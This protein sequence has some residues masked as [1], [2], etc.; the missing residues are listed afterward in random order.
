VTLIPA[1]VVEMLNPGSEL[2]DLELGPPFY[3]MHGVTD[4]IVFDPETTLVLHRRISETVRR[5]SP[6]TIDLACG[7]RL[8]AYSR[9][10]PTMRGL[11]LPTCCAH[12]H[13]R[14]GGGS[15]G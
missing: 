2:K 4:V 9:G 10:G 8:T 3:L 11:A 6:V 15:G 5:Q 13:A 12:G 7:C 14:G 1:A